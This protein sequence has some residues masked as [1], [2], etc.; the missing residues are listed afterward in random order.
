MRSSGQ[1]YR[2]A[3]MPQAIKLKA[4]L[5]KKASCDCMKIL[6]LRFQPLRAAVGKIRLLVD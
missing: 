5:K 2:A 6:L 1:K 3:T 4:M